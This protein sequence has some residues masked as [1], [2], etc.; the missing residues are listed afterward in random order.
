MDHASSGLECLVWHEDGIPCVKCKNCAEWLRPEDIQ[1][2]CD[3]GLPATE[4][5][6]KKGCKCPIRFNENNRKTYIINIGCPLHSFLVMGVLN[7]EQQ[8]TI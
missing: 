7:N 6:L 1:Q 3:G 2:E 8:N 5:A 4:A